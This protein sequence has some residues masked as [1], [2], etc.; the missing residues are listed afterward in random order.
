MTTGKE[1]GVGRCRLHHVDARIDRTEA[2]GARLVLDG[3]LRLAEIQLRPAAPMPRVRQVR[4]ENK[5]L[6]DEGGA[7]IQLPHNKC[8]RVSGETERTSIVLAEFNS[9]LSRLFVSA[10]SSWEVQPSPFRL[11]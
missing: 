6:V 9:P 2:H 8:E 7:I 10:T 5:R 3:R 11:Q 1:M 4:V